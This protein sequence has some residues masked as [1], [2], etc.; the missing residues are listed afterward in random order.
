MPG[1]VVWIVCAESVTNW[2]SDAPTS[3]DAPP[4]EP[5]GGLARHLTDPVPVLDHGGIIARG[6]KDP[7]QSSGSRWIGSLWGRPQSSYAQWLVGRRGHDVGDALD[8]A[9]RGRMA[10]HLHPDLELVRRQCPPFPPM[11]GGGWE[12][13]HLGDQGRVHRYGDL[14][15]PARL[16]RIDGRL[17]LIRAPSNGSPSIGM[18]RFPL[19]RRR[20]CDPS[21]TSPRAPSRCR[22]RRTDRSRSWPGSWIMAQASQVL[23]RRQG[24]QLHLDT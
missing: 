14:E 9:H 21:R 2:L 7:A 4:P 6:R 11:P 20:S 18:R 24:A 3:I 1:G 19:A 13:T 15:V 17:A 8:D 5:P 16:E 12:D 23:R 22:I 10:G